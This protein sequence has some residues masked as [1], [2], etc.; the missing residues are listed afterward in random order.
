[1]LLLFLALVPIKVIRIIDGDTFKGLS[2]LDTVTIRLIGVD[3]P[4]SR[5]NTKAYN[6]AEKSENDVETIVAMGELAKEFTKKHLKENETVY[7]EFDVGENDKYG[8]ILAY[9]WLNDTLMF[10]NFILREGYAQIMTIPPNVKYQ[11]EFLTAYK[12]ARENEKGLWSPILV[13]PVKR[14]AVGKE[15]ILPEFYIGNKQ[16]KIFHNPECSSAK[17]M[18]DENKVIFNSSEEASNAGFRPCKRCNP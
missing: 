4:E 16:S 2:G 11:E 3:C 14:H 18:S 13:L 1:M 17:R 6:D 9:V 10:N 5:K 12:S 7:L 8:R 15:Q